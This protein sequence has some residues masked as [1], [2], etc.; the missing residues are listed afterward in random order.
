MGAGRVK[1]DS[2]LHISRAK[3]WTHLLV[4]IAIKLLAYVN[5]ILID[6]Y[7]Y[8]I[9]LSF[10]LIRVVQRDSS[11][12]GIVNKQEEHKVIMGV[13]DGSG[14]YTLVYEDNEGDRMLVGD[15]PWQ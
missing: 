11:A 9:C 6:R 5:V 4:L 2:K 13:L 12:G 8:L 10:A 14:E 7:G 3:F 15:V 1:S